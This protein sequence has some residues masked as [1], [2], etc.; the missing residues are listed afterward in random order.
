MHGMT[1]AFSPRACRSGQFSIYKECLLVSCLWREKL[2][3]FQKDNAA[4]TTTVLS[5]QCDSI[6]V[7][8]DHLKIKRLF[9]F[10]QP[11]HHL[12]CQ[13]HNQEE[14]QLAWYISINFSINCKNYYSGY[15][16]STVAWAYNKTEHWI[17]LNGS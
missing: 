12:A 5:F 7:D 13:H 8:K 16:G 4:K 6:P 9:Q 2:P 11:I 1:F 15:S 3:I 17:K 14:Y 10:P